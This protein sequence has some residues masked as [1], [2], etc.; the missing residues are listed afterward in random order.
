MKEYFITINLLTY[1]IE[2]VRDT[3]EEA[4]EA[5]SGDDS[6]AVYPHP[7]REPIASGDTISEDMALYLMESYKA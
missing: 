3:R 4:I 6:I 5:A 1:T 7:V 2:H